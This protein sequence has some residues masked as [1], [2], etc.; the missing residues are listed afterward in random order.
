MRRVILTGG[1][2]FIGSSLVRRLL[3]AGVEG[4][5]NRQ[6]ENHQRLDSVLPEQRW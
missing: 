2:G 4:A 5:R 6:R 1:N 3:S